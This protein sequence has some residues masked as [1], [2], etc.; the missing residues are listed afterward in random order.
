MKAEIME[1]GEIVDVDIQDGKIYV[2][3]ETYRKMMSYVN[4]DD[5]KPLNSGCFEVTIQL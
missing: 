1:T 2:D 4:S 5:L 3:A